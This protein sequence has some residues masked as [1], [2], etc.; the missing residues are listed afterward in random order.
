MSVKH[1]WRISPSLLISYFGALLTWLIF[2]PGLFSVD[3][4]NIYHQAL[5]GNFIGF[6]PPLLA[7]ALRLF[8]RVG[9]T[10]GLFIL[11]ACLLGFLGIR[12]LSLAVMKYF[13][14]KADRQEWVVCLV[15]LILSFPLTPMM[16]YFATLWVDTWLTIYLLSYC[17]VLEMA[18]DGNR[19][20][21][22]K[23]QSSSY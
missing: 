23:L 18:M 21:Y 20:S 11:V 1:Q 4:L 3:S 14:V 17:I 2:Y 16:I 9:G 8:L 6:H 13:S 19:I 10:V 22:F 12:R 7:L 15:F 5:T